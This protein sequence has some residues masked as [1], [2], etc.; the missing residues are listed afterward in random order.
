MSIAKFTHVSETQYL[1]AMSG[2][3]DFLPLRTGKLIEHRTPEKE[4]TDG[5]Q[6][7]RKQIFQR[8]DEVIRA[9]EL[10]RGLLDDR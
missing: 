2:R 9:D 7:R 3:E 8:A 5:K 6:G 10:S 4:G 1:E